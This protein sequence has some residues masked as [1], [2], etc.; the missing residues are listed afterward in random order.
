MFHKPKPG[1]KPE[2]VNHRHPECSR[3]ENRI[4]KSK[5]GSFMTLTDSTYHFFM[6]NQVAL[7]PV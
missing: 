6:Y 4:I 3:Y 2:Q 7:K 5:L 1:P